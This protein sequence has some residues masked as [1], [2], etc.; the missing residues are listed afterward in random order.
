MHFM[1]IRTDDV[2]YCFFGRNAFGA[3]VAITIH[4]FVDGAEPE[5]L[6]QSWQH[7][8]ETTLA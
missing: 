7:Y 3:P 6:E 4:L 1:G 2:L 8:L 5:Q